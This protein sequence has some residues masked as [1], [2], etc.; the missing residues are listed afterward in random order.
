MFKT[1]VEGFRSS[2]LVDDNLPSSY[3]RVGCITDL[4]Q[5]IYTIIVSPDSQMFAYGGKRGPEVHMLKTTSLLE[6]PD[7]YPEVY[8]AVTILHWLDESELLTGTTLGF[9]VIWSENDEKF[10]LLAHIR[11]LGSAEVISAASAVQGDGFRIVVGMLDCTVACIDWCMRWG[12]VYLWNSWSQHSHVFIPRAVSIQE[13]GSVCILSLHNGKM[14][15]LDRD[16]GNCIGAPASFVDPVGSAAIDKKKELLAIA[17]SGGFTLHDLNSREGIVA[18]YKV[19]KS[20]T[21]LPKPIIFSEGHR[22]VIIGS[23]YGKAYIFNKRKGGPPVDTLI[24]SDD[25]TEL[26]Q[27]VMTHYDGERS[28]ILCVTLLIKKP[29][30]STWEQTMPGRQAKHSQRT[31]NPVK[32][33][34]KANNDPPTLTVTSFLQIIVLLCILSPVEAVAEW[35]K[36]A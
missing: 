8:G 5:P 18:V 14:F 3:Q 21:D 6:I 17:H 32:V 2:S 15:I 26:V 22:V 16:T 30:I 9:L 34:V 13:D 19:E 20:C 31:E 36:G 11:M 24:H 35:T 33:S 7:F 29:S 25:P 4:G 23:D 12:L 10:S 27:S 28:I 1:F